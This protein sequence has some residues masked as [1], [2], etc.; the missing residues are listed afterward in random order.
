MNNATV[1]DFSSTNE[2]M[3]WILSGTTE[4]A[5]LDSHGIDGPTN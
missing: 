3:Y 2:V 4:I 5:G 1:S